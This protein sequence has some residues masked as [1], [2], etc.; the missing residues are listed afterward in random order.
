MVLSGLGLLAVSA[1]LLL[2]LVNRSRERRAVLREAERLAG[3][4]RAD[5]ATR[6]L[7]RYLDLHPRDAEVMELQAELFDRLFREVGVVGEVETLAAIR[8]NERL[9]PLVS[10]ENRKEVDR[11]LAYL[12]VKFSDSLYQS[13]FYR[14]VPDRLTEE[15]RYGAAE[16][17][18]RRL[19][20]G[21]PGDGGAHR[22]LA[23]AMQGQ[24][25]PGD[26]AAL[27]ETIREYRKALELDPGDIESGL[28]LA[29]IYRDRDP[30]ELGRLHQ[31]EG[32]GELKSLN[33][34]D[35]RAMAAKVLDGVAAARPNDADIR[36]TRYRYFR[37]TRA[38]IDRAVAELKKAMELEPNSRWVRLAAAE[39][40]TRAG[41]FEEARKHLAAIPAQEGV[42]ALQVK[43]VQGVI[44]FAAD[45]PDEALDQWRRGLIQVQ[46][47]H[48]Q[49]NWWLA[50][51]NLRRGQFSAARPYMQAYER[52][53]TDSVSDPGLQFLKAVYDE[54]SGNPSEALVALEKITSVPS[55]SQLAEEI[56]MARGRCLE[57]QGNGDEALRAYDL[58]QRLAPGSVMPTLARSSVL[59]RRSP[60]EAVSGLRKALLAAPEEPELMVALARAEITRLAALPRGDRVEGLAALEKLLADLEKISSENTALDLLRADWLRLGDHLDRS[61]ALLEASVKARPTDRRLWAAWAETLVMD[62][63]MGR[64][65]E[66]LAE[67]SKPSA[68]G[69]NATLRLI[70]GRLLVNLGR[71]R[72][73]QAAMVGGIEGLPA[74]QKVV[75]WEALGRLR[76]AQ[77]DEAGARQAYLA[78]N[79]EV[80]G[81]PRPLLA[82]LQLALRANDQASANRLLGQ[83]GQIDP[84]K[85][86]EASGHR[87]AEAAEPTGPTYRLARAMILYTFSQVDPNKATA[88]ERSRALLDLRL[89]KDIVDGL[90]LERKGEPDPTTFAVRGQIWERLGD[91]DEAIKD[92]RLA[93]ERGVEDVYPR[94]L[95]LLAQRGRFQ[96]IEKIQRPGSGALASGLA[97]LAL[98]GAGER[99]ISG[100]LLADL[101]NDPARDEMV[102]LRAFELAGQFDD[103][104]RLLRNRAEASPRNDA[105]EP[106]L[107]LIRRQADHGRSA[108]VLE[109]SIGS[110][111]KLALTPRIDLLE[112]QARRTARLWAGAERA[113]E[114][115][116]AR[117]STDPVALAE[118]ASYYEE[119]GRMGRALE[120]YRQA[121]K[122]DPK[123]RPNARQMAVAMSSQAG[124]EKS[125]EEAW[126]LVQPSLGDQAEDRLARAIVLA[127]SPDA[128]R[129]SQA[130]PLL[131]EIVADLD[132]SQSTAMAA[133]D[134]MARL[135][136]LSGQPDRASAYAR[137][138]ADLTGSSHDLSLYAECLMA[139]GRLSDAETALDRLF[140]TDPIA[141]DEA[142]LRARLVAARSADGKAPGALA[143]EVEN[144]GRGPAAIAL[145]RAAF[146]QILADA[147]PKPGAESLDAAEK[148]AKDLASLNPSLGWMVGRVAL[149]R[150]KPSEAM[151]PCRSAAEAPDGTEADRAEAGRVSLAAAAQGG[152]T[153]EEV[154][155]ILDAAIRYQ[156]N[157]AELMSMR[158]IVH[159]A[160]GEYGPEV[161]L[162]RRVLELVPPAHPQTDQVVNNLAW[163]LSEGLE[164]PEEAL[165]LIE[166]LIQRR[167]PDPQWLCT[168]GVVLLRLGKL[169]QAIADLRASSESTPPNGRRWFHLA[170]AYRAAGR[171]DQA[172]DSLEQAKRA[173]LTEAGVDTTERADFQTMLSS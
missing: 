92:Y 61:M 83:I 105:I 21:D 85:W 113:Y 3:S 24:A 128:S 119:T 79:D 169:D 17:I 121:L 129:S 131:T 109:A 87:P 139:A 15:T 52:L 78:W 160:Q 111:L 122:V 90:I 156:P 137:V 120:L 42:E 125:W 86:K 136:L 91:A 30:K 158:A 77:G 145:G 114:R 50:Y 94:L 130:L 69:D 155:S 59:L 165:P 123:S 142:R 116:A 141:P 11:R 96:E 150:G 10:G 54:Q 4:N 73:A 58:A 171:M 146:E 162:Y 63:Q 25:V 147:G 23:M 93:W 7:G 144:R 103:V 41:Q 75:L 110:L 167:G 72:E 5:L 81:S 148:I 108:E 127:R 13:R 140:L 166:G 6:H 102:R 143:D 37:E 164:K 89:A 157:S 135:L 152:G 153:M 56:A 60:E 26:P 106:W 27:A 22:L 115:A 118:V 46:G 43:V 159:H 124:D 97:G 88:A 117:S 104:E 168:R 126:S 74:D 133:R 112:A 65:L 44:E 53:T 38:D 51:V 47:S 64:A 32:Y 95:D 149:L 62:G 31:L 170:R 68:A 84:S 33:G 35:L 49:L 40:A 172:R 132:P 154:A 45:R 1:V 101:G 18:A 138:S 71:G 36:L 99:E 12:Y 80:R 67:G 134:Y 66:V 8:L 76:T 107:E 82:L 173:G 100:K 34:A 55:G 29:R 48:A 70:R 98:L 163:A 2:P 16:E 9:Q 20:A 14:D 151:A 39:Q 57:S 19:V 161:S 28:Q